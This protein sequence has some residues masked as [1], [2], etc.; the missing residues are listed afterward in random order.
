[1][2]FV[3]IGKIRGVDQ[4]ER[5]R[6]EQFAFFAFARGGFDQLGGIPFAEIDLDALG[7]QPAFEQV[8]LRGLARTIEAFDGDQSSGKIQFRK[9]FHNPRPPRLLILTQGAAGHKRKLRVRQPA[10]QPPKSGQS[11]LLVKKITI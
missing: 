7:F 3:T 8:N 2:P 1:M 11:G 4:T 9:S 6:R 5:R 10:I